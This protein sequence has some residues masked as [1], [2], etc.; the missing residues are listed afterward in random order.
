LAY[1]RR[2]ATTFREKSG[3]AGYEKIYEGIIYGKAF[4]RGVSVDHIMEYIASEIAQEYEVLDNQRIIN[5][6]R[7]IIIE[8]LGLQ[9]LK[10]TEK[11]L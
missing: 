3:V 1:S 2:Y 9:S 4:I 7:K 11:S 10:D 5:E 8:I 6:M